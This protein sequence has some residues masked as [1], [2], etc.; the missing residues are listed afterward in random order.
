M[1]SLSRVKYA[2]RGQI[3]F[4]L[5]AQLFLVDFADTRLGDLIGD[6]HPVGNAVLGN[7]AVFDEVHVELLQILAGDLV[8]VVGLQD[9]QG[10]GAFPPFVVG[11]PDDGRLTDRLV[12]AD[13]VFQF[14]G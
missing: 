12:L 9:H 13:E 11:D 6:D 5:G 7:R 10:Q 8:L 2:R 3:L 4:V 14:Q 1:G